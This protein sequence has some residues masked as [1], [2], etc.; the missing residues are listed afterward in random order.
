MLD[1]NHISV[2]ARSRVGGSPETFNKIICLGPGVPVGSKKM[3]ST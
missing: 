2:L 1:G 3:I